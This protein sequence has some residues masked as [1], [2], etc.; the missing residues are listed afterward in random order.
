MVFLFFKILMSVVFPLSIGF[1]VVSFLLRNAK[2]PAFFVLALSYGLGLG[3]LGVWM[4]VLGGLRLPISVLSVY[5]PLA[6]GAALLLWRPIRQGDRA[7]G[8]GPILTANRPSYPGGILHN[9]ATGLMV[10][11]VLYIAVNIG[12][13]FWKAIAYPVSTVPAM[14]T[15]ALQAKMIFTGQ[16][17]P[18]LNR[19]PQPSSPLLVPLVQ[20]WTAYHCG[21]WNEFWIKLPF[22]CVLLSFVVCVY[23]FLAYYT[24]RFWAL[25]GC[26]MLL[27]S[28][29]LIRQAT[30]AQA[31]LFV[32]YYNCLTVMLLCLWMKA[33]VRPLL[34]I[35]ALLAAVSTLVSLEGTGYFGIY[36]L[37]FIVINSAPAKFS[38]KTKMANC[39]IFLLPGLAVAGLFYLHNMAYNPPVQATTAALPQN[40]GHMSALSALDAVAINMFFSG[41]W[42]ISWFFL[43]LSLTHVRKGRNTQEVILF[44]LALFLFVEFTILTG[45]ISANSAPMPGA[46]GALAVSASILHYYPLAV[47]GAILICFPLSLDKP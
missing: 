4:Y 40:T 44:L 45:L 19:L 13:V 33:G 8:Y 20:S 3:I 9:G 1:A 21:S 22:P 34:W 15:T 35:A 23:A 39:L 30:V 2:V 36:L 26:T 5:V 41:N 14:A 47:I 10:L 12:Y 24:N 37:L 7:A 42:G 11:M 29:F 38:L 31:G 17:L 16:A 28:N 18:S 32:M 25:V 46:P 6:I 27:S 43:V